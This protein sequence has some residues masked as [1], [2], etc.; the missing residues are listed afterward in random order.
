MKGL[1]LGTLLGA[2]LVVGAIASACG[3]VTTQGSPG[4]GG[5]GGSSAGSAGTTGAGGHGGTTG[6]GGSTAGSAGGGTTGTG[7]SVAGSAGT[8]GAGGNAAG[9]RGGNAGATGLGGMGPRGVASHQL[10]NGGGVVQSSNYRMVFT[11]GQPT[12]QQTTTTSATYRMRGGLIGA[13]GT[14]P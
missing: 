1:R 13:T 10:V 7:G 9:G 12:P 8:T 6:T 11:V 3:S 2:L 14:P 5:S 4:T